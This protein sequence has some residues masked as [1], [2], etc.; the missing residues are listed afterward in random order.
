[1][2][3]AATIHTD[4]QTCVQEE[5]DDI[6]ESIRRNAAAS[7]CVHTREFEVETRFAHRA[8]KDMIWEGYLIPPC[9]T[10]VGNLWAIANDPEVFRESHE[11]SYQH[12]IDHADRVR[13]FSFG[14]G[15]RVCP[16]QHVANRERDKG[17]E[18]QEDKKNERSRLRDL[19]SKT[20]MMNHLSQPSRISLHREND[21]QRDAKH[22]TWGKMKE[23]YSCR[24][25]QRMLYIPLRH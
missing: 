24:R 23:A 5:L 9:V 16:G 1:M 20:I 12:W 8:T 4:A 3:M 14:F 6:A 11:F 10:A 25:R 7:Y 22:R 13:G 18:Y 15:C 19:A 2:M 21:R 17:K